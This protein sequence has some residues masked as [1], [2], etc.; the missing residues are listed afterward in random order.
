MMHSKHNT[1]NYNI[2]SI[3]FAHAELEI[4]LTSF[5]P[6]RQNIP[7]VTDIHENKNNNSNNNSLSSSIDEK[8]ISLLIDQGYSRG[9]AKLLETSKDAFAKRIWI[10][11]N[12]GSMQIKDGN[13]I[14]ETKDRKNVN[15]I[16]CTRWEEIRECMNYHIQLAGLIRAPSTFR[17]LN[18]P[19]RHCGP[20]RF[21][22]ATNNN[23]PYVNDG[24]IQNA[25]KIMQKVGPNGCTPLTMH[26]LDIQREVSLMADELRR[27]GQRVAIIIA[28]DG[29]PTDECGRNSTALQNEF[30]NSLRQMEG[31]P[32]W[33]VIRLC[34]D[35]DRIVHFYNKL[36]SVLEISI[37][38]LDDF[39][40]EA[41]EVYQYNPWLNYALPIHRMREMGY[42]DRIFDM[43][44]ERKFTISEVR[45]FCLLLFGDEYFDGAPDPAV[46]WIQ[47]LK[48]MENTLRKENTQWN[49][50][51]RKMTPWINLS[52]LK[53]DYGEANCLCM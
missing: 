38:V 14:V 24:G 5:V 50:V 47:F 40:C 18:D 48:F 12:S 35:E 28:T 34:T 29:L 17:F 3:P 16:P 13:R 6:P 1:A 26:I 10:I 39:V 43:L 53:K 30:V 36:D 32:V 31:L 20:Q 51:K 22:V 21:E 15:F 23:E 4:D 33:I 42:H 2:D 41:K 19:G 46:D 52:S 44:D 45:E 8:H 9:L 11:D 7:V 37:E 49:P 25:L 27:A